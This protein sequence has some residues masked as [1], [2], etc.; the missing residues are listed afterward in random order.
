M[1]KTWKAFL[2]VIILSAIAI[3]VFASGKKED[4]AGMR[5]TQEGFPARDIR[6]ICPWGA[7]GGADGI[8][9]KSAYLAEKEL[10]VSIL[11]Y[12]PKTGRR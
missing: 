5:V 1:K 10:P 2:A 4:T 7:G 12:P 11:Q 6:V 3:S 8:S 9:R